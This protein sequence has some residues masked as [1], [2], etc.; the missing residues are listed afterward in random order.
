MASRPFFAGSI[1]KT[2]NYGVDTR[3]CLSAALLFTV[4]FLHLSCFRKWNTDKKSASGNHLEHTLQQNRKDTNCNCPDYNSSRLYFI[5]IPLTQNHKYILHLGKTLVAAFLIMVMVDTLGDMSDGRKL[6]KRG[7]TY[8]RVS[9]P[10]L[11]PHYGMP[12]REAQ[13]QSFL[14]YE[15]AFWGWD[16][17]G[18]GK[19][20]IK[21][22]AMA[23]RV[24]PALNVCR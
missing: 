4:R 1:C 5:S 16:R 2:I 12:L 11:L 17:C 7:N 24:A 21:R 3:K 22:T 15:P 9:C 13:Y 8:H 18:R 20:G 14:L 23:W 6:S 19:V 10:R